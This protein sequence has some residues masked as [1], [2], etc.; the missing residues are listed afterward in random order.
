M[1]ANGLLMSQANSE[2]GKDLQTPKQPTDNNQ[3]GYQEACLIH[4]LDDNLKNDEVPCDKES[5]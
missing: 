3:V 1:D 4:C 5:E 2:P